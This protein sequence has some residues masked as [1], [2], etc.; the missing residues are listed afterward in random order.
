MKSIVMTLACAACLA[1]AGCDMTS[2]CTAE[3]GFSVEPSGQVLRVGQS[4]A[5]EARAWTCGGRETLTIDVLW[6]SS[7]SSIVS[8]AQDGTATALSVGTASVHGTD[9]SRYEAGPFE[10]PVTVQP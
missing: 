5:P 3:L 1:T 10:V 8:V 6:T 7:D 2:S 4:F 9:Q